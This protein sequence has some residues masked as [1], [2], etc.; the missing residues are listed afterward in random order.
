M[1]RK[2]FLL[3]FI[4]SCCLAARGGELPDSLQRILKQAGTD[5]ARIQILLAASNTNTNTDPEEA[6]RYA[7]LAL[8]MAQKSGNRNLVAKSYYYLGTN[9]YEMNS[10]DKSHAWFL[11]AASLYDS[12]HDFSGMALAYSAL[13]DVISD[14]GDGGKSIAYYGRAKKN[15][16]SAGDTLQAIYM[17]MSIAGILGTVINK[18]DS[19]VSLSLSILPKAHRTKDD[20]LISKVLAN[21]AVLYQMQGNYQKALDYSIKALPYFERRGDYVM[22]AMTYGSIAEDYVLLKNYN[23]AEKYALLEYES[24]K[25]GKSQK[26]IVLA[27]QRLGTVAK[28]KKDYAAAAQW[29]EKA[30]I[31]KDSLFTSDIA[32]QVTEMQTKYETEKKEQAIDK[33]NKEAQLQEAQISRQRL[34]R[35]LIIAIALFVLL[36]AGIL[37]RNYK[38]S[39]SLNRQLEEQKAKLEELDV[40]KNKLFSAISH[41]LRSPMMSLDA[42]L[43]LLQQEN[44]TQER[45]K[46]YTGHINTSMNATLTLLD[47]LLNWS[48]SQMKGLSLS[49]AEVNLKELADENIQLYASAAGKKKISIVSEIGTDASAYIDRNIGRLVIRNLLNNA[50]KFTPEKGQITL[51][52]VDRGNEVEIQVK[53]NGIG[54]AAQHV[55][56]LFEL[57]MGNTRRGT[58]KEKGTGLGLVLCKE[59]IEKSGGNIS[60]ESEEGKGSTFKVRLPKTLSVTP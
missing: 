45:L 10:L 13:G 55:K 24:Y 9:A 20:G 23:S 47:N 48:L 16:L 30:L 31:A 46:A 52:S 51:S 29:F 36:V 15:F 11:L 39:Q 4:C 21:I 38:R 19:A 57:R 17:D 44:I 5:Q 18:T 26:G 27:M 12:L 3:L 34:V 25:K 54:M 60:V 28:E 43:D 32:A 2:L 50:I 22:S 42:T 6:T 35:N 41:D 53:D 8:E 40:I 1:A 58:A 59:L 49:P 33:L 37:Y 14:E 7:T 56:M